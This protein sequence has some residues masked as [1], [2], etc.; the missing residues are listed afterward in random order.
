M[1]TGKLFGGERVWGG[2]ERCFRM[3]GGDGRM[4]VRGDGSLWG[5]CMAR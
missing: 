3:G 5:Y 1:L 2:W 4:T